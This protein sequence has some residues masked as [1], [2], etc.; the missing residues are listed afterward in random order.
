MTKVLRCSARGIFS[1]R[2][3]SSD[4]RAA[5]NCKLKY[6][7]DDNMTTNHEYEEFNNN[8]IIKIH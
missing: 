3:D 8:K 1:I 7:R 4:L 6:L 2:N 5:L